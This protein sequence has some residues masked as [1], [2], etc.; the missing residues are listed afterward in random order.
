LLFIEELDKEDMFESLRQIQKRLTSITNE[1]ERKYYAIAHADILFRLGSVA[2]ALTQYK[3]LAD[4]YEYDQVGNL[5][6]YG[7]ALIELGEHKFHLARVRLTKLLVR[8]PAR[9]P[10]IPHVRL[11]VAESM[12]ATGQYAQMVQLLEWEGFP[13]SLNEAVELRRA[14][15]A[16]ATERFD[17]AFTTYDKFYGSEAMATHPYSNNGYC[18]LL[19]SRQAFEESRRCYLDLASMLRDSSDA[20]SALYLATLAE[21]KA[22]DLSARPEIL[23][24]TIVERFPGT[25]AALL[26]EMKQADLCALAQDECTENASQWFHRI[27]YRASSRALAESAS[28]KEA[29]TFFLDGQQSKSIDLL[30]T[31]LRTYQ[32]GELLDQVHALLI[33]LLPG[34]IKRLLEAGLDIEAIA[35]AQQNRALFEK[36]WLDDAL[37]FELGLGLE[38]LAMYPE[39]LQLFLYLKNRSS[40]RDREGLLLGAIRSAHAL[41]AHNLVENLAAEYMYRYPE[42]AR[43]LDVLFYRLDCTYAAG[44]I[45]EALLMLPDPLP[46]RLDYRLLAA[47]LYF[48]NKQYQRTADLLLSVYQLQQ[49]DLPADPLY[50][51]AESLYELGELSKCEELFD[52]LT[53]TKKYQ[54]AARH[55]IVQLSGAQEREQTTELNAYLLAGEAENDPWHRFARQDSRY[56]QLL[57]NL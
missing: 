28:F 30:Q 56:R 54:Q 14:D 53:E 8:L 1:E 4:T 12:L 47:T 25:E 21:L 41:G 37:L 7:A 3:L 45:D 16:Y 15:H 13:P 31:M 9:H 52:L 24:A 29:L 5:A 17:E 6:V 57:S 35:L 39:A 50:M 34:E 10:L 55:R 18:S 32:S 51:L 33:Q 49:E 46:Q 27:A 44:Q 42:G 40:S 22:E 26:A 11:A 48:Q 2:A 43:Q 38:R 19:F 36:G 20:G 23:F